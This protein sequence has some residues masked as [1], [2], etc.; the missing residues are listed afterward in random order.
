ME[1]VLSGVSLPALCRLITEAL[2]AGLERR[3]WSLGAVG[4]SLAEIRVE[5]ESNH[6][7]SVREMLLELVNLAAHSNASQN[8]AIQLGGGLQAHH[9]ITTG[10]TEHVDEWRRESH[11]ST[12]IIAFTVALV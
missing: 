11:T 10:K 4:A 6:H 5:S 2:G 3:D 7:T 12:S 1:G 9:Y 8:Y